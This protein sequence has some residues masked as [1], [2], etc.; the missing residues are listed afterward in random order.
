MTSSPEPIYCTDCEE[1]V[2]VLASAEEEGGSIY[3]NKFVACGCTTASENYE[4]PE[5]LL[6]HFDNWERREWK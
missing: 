3:V 2:A 6:S 1:Y 4:D 5:P